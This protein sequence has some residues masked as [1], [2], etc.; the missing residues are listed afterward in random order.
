MFSFGGN[1]IDEYSNKNNFFNTDGIDKKYFESLGS[2]DLAQ[3]SLIDFMFQNPSNAEYILTTFRDKYLEEVV[4]KALSDF[5]K[6]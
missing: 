3:K 5:F 4:I 2:Y 6:A 1:F